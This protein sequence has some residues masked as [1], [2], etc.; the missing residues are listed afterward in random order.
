[1]KNL[2][3]TCLLLCLLPVAVLS[4]PDGFN[5]DESKVPA[6]TL[7]DPLKFEDGRAVSGP[8]QWPA[9]RAELLTLFAEQ[10]YGVMPAA[11]DRLKY[12]VIESDEKALGGLARRKQVR[13]YFG[14]RNK[15]PYMDLLIYLPAN[16]TRRVP[17][18]L[19]LNFKGNH[20]VHIDPAIRLPQSWLANDATFGV[21]ENRASEAGRG[22]RAGR[23]PIEMILGRGYGVATAYYGDIDPDFDDGFQNGV[24]PLFYAEDQTQPKPQEWGS[25]AAWAWG[26]SRCMDYLLLEPIVDPSRVIVMGHSRLGKAAMW[27]GV[28]DD[29]FAAMIS[30]DSGCGGAALSRRKFGET[31]QRINT[32]FPHWFC[33]NFPAYN[34]KEE[35]LPFDQHQLIALMAPRPVLVCSAEGDQWADPKG[36]FLSCVA[37]SPVYELLGMKGMDTQEMPGLHR[38]TGSAIGY[39]IRAGGHDL[40]GVDWKVF[41][42]FMDAR[43]A[44]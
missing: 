37:A 16:P 35:T 12:E 19:G 1:M 9:R 14:K 8:A 24:H 15:M 21:T 26:L 36:E 18:I 11:P 23:W 25:I 13:I 22:L 29:R 7:P 39:H 40:T 4:Q 30:N 34:D 31:V 20:T 6:Y 44:E 17:V 3:L 42:D 10:M 41:M 38:L 27:A 28:T 5:Y 33:D 43:L 2:L 32:S